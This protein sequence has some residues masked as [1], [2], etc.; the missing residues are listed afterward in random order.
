MQP[1]S[2]YEPGR[3]RRC[4]RRPGG[5]PP[6]PGAPAGSAEKS[7]WVSMPRQ[8]LPGRFRGDVPAFRVLLGPE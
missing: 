1:L 7:L 2:M 4:S 6:Q 8:G 3:K 5:F